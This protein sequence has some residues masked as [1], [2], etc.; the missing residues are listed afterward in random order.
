[1]APG[2]VRRCTAGPDP[3]TRGRARGSG[4]R[5]GANVFLRGPMAG[6]D[7]SHPSLPLLFLRLRGELLKGG[8]RRTSCE[9]HLEG[10]EPCASARAGRQGWP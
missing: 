3:G 1:V 10:R 8:D 7:V 4:Y 6:V 5:E 2:Q 9:R